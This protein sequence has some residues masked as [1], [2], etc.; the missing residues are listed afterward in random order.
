MQRRV[1]QLVLQYMN[2]IISCILFVSSESTCIALYCVATVLLIGPMYKRSV[3]VIGKPIG[4]VVL[5]IY[6]SQ[7][8]CTCNIY[9]Y[10]FTS[11]H[12]CHYHDNR[13]GTL[14]SAMYHISSK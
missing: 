3:I 12:N 1:P 7:Y 2:A 9:I 11:C 5:F 8:S 10:K 6:V 13:E 4:L 14:L